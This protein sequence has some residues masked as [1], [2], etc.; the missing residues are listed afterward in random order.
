[1]ARL[2]AFLICPRGE[3]AP[4]E[5]DDD[6]SPVASK[7][8]VP[9][10]LLPCVD[11]YVGDRAW[12]A[13]VE[14]VTQV[15]LAIAAAASE[16]FP[17]P[18][19]DGGR[20]V[21]GANSSS[22]SSLSPL[23][24]FSAADDGLGIKSC[25]AVGWSTVAVLGVYLVALVAACPHRY[26]LLYYTALV[27]NA[28]IF[29]LTVATSSIL[30]RAI[31]RGV[32]TAADAEAIAALAVA[33]QVVAL[34]QTLYALA[35]QV[36]DLIRAMRSRDALVFARRAR[37]FARTTARTK[38]RARRANAAHEGNVSKTFC[39]QMTT[40]SAGHGRGH[41]AE[42]WELDAMGSTA[43]ASIP[44]QPSPTVALPESPSRLNTM[45]RRSQRV[46]DDDAQAAL[47]ERLRILLL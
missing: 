23:S 27:P 8:L 32:F 31:V 11:D 28:V 5:E 34:L 3:W 1:L 46:D 16:F 7:W 10:I 20:F 2:R 12:F 37:C 35:V 17:L 18:P 19:S 33:L 39:H 36:L 15:A 6:A 41:A 22:L 43:R 44:A 38:A 13:A 25:A 14:A 29:V 47:E 30:Q 40:A 26:R 42:S 45:L 4:R 21:A 24:S 9:S